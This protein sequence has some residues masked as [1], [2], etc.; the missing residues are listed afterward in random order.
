MLTM[1]SMNP[2]W[3]FHPL[4][5]AGPVFDRELR[6]ASRRRRSYVL[7]FVYVGLL[8]AFMVAVWS[9]LVQAGS[10]GSLVY[11]SSQRATAGRYIAVAIVWF[12]F[13]AAQIGAPMLLG[14]AI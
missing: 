2:I 14:D 10:S 6:V 12:Q 8:T 1:A 13:V 3:C 4:W 7:R 11:Q 5:W 9:S